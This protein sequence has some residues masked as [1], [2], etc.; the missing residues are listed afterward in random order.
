MTVSKSAI[1]ERIKSRIQKDPATGCHVYCGAWSSRGYGLIR[2]GHK[3]YTIQRVVAWLAGKAELWEDVYR[4]RK[5]QTPAC[6]NPRHIKIAA[7]FGEALKEMRR[8][9]VFSLKG[10]VK[11]TKAR[12]ACIV[13]LA[14]EGFS[15]KEIAVDLGMRPAK[16]RRVIDEGA[17]KHGRKNPRR[18]VGSD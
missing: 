16:I 18:A 15:A 12:R 1:R 7:S 8:L 17:K 9:G 6:A 11:L 2:V 14:E 13:L 3:T 4:Y 5:C 10:T